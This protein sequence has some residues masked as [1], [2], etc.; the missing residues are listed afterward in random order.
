VKQHIY[1]SLVSRRQRLGL[2]QQEL[3]SRA[4]L[5]REK[6]NRI[7]SRA[8]DVGLD[9]L[10][11][12]L[13]ALGLEL[14]V[15]EKH[16]SGESASRHRAESPAARYLVPRKLRDASFLDGSKARVVRWGKLPR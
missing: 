6:V 3:A 7:E 2:S 5:R 12:V 11:R 4:G 14:R 10:C 15:V 16:A 13:D 1:A 9:E 8:E